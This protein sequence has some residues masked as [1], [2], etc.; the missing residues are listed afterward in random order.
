MYVKTRIIEADSVFRFARVI[1]V[2]V[3]SKTI[4]TPKRALSASTNH[5]YDE[6]VLK[7]KEK[8]GLTEIYL[9]INHENLRKAMDN[10]FYRRSFTNKLSSLLKKAADNITIG[11]VECDF[12]GNVPTKEETEFIVHLLN[13]P[14]LDILVSP[15][16]LGVPAKDYVKFLDQFA[17][18]HQTCSFHAILAPVIPHYSTA[19]IPKLFKYYMSRDEF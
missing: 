15:I 1:E 11:I 9:R 3:G 18:I 10:E 8:K 13:N 4:I 16:L 6:T 7:G 2:S 19:D 12:A 14:D 17:E 5:I